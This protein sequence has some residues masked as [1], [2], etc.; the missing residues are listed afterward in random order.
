VTA[1]PPTLA[2]P[3]PA[4]PSPAAAIEAAPTSPA[5]ATPGRAARVPTPSADLGAE[6]AFLDSARAAVSAGAGRRALD[7]LRGYQS[8]YPSGSFRP[9]AT[10]IK[11]EALA[12]LGRNAEARALATQFVAEHRGSLL[13]ARVAEL[14]GLAAPAPAP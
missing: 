12:K 7:I 6:I 2:P 5:P 9:E 1:P 10:A 14:V 13:A 4:P 11:I 8:R 3:A